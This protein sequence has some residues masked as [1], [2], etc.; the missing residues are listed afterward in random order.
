M[1]EVS[2]GAKL[3]LRIGTVPIAYANN[4]QYNLEIVTEAIQGIDEIKIDEY[5]EV[6]TRVTFTASM[7]R[8]AFKAAFSLG[9]QPKIENL[10]RQPELTAQIKDKT[11]GVV[12]LKMNGLKLVG[13]SG[14]VN[15]RG[16]WTETLSFVARRM[17]DEGE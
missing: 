2:T 4:V 9:I 7:F 12:L 8:V 6:G 5:A 17:F 15:A 13:R 3:E 1:S 14:T 16:I 10:L 11:Q